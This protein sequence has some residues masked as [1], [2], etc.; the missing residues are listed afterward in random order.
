AGQIRFLRFHPYGVGLENSST[1]NSYNPPV[2]G[3]AEN[4]SVA[5]A[6]SRTTTN[7]Q[8]GVWEVAVEVRRTSDAVAVPY[9]LT[10]SILGATVTPNP[11]TI[12]SATLG[13]PVARSYTLT[14]LFG[15]FTG[16][17]VGT[18]LGSAKMDTPSIAHHAQLQFPVTVTA[19]ST[20]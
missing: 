8:A 13:V 4:C 3:C 5:A 18:T 17:A 10:M 12:A 14:N 9:S 6:T 7:P 16:R 11:D 19:G 20:S 15:A 1:P 2:P